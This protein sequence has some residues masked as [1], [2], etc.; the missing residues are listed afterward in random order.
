MSHSSRNVDLTDISFAYDSKRCKIKLDENNFT[1]GGTEC[2]REMKNVIDF[3][4][5]LKIFCILYVYFFRK[6][7]Y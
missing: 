7:K 3:I 2:A 4:D 6:L 5:K 1:N